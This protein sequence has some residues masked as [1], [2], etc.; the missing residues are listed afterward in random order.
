MKTKAVLEVESRTVC[1]ARGLGLGECSDPLGTG[2]QTHERKRGSGWRQIC[3][4][5]PEAMA[6]LCPGHH[7]LV[8]LNP[9]VGL[10]VG[11]VWTEGQARRELRELGWESKTDV[12]RWT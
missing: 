11:L 8:T 7:E 6:R 5:Y 3:R 9:D 2:L 4:R 1:E 10:K 12:T